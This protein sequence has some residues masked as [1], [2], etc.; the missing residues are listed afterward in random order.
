MKAGASGRVDL[1]VSH[2]RNLHRCA[3]SAPGLLHDRDPRLEQFPEPTKGT[4]PLTAMVVRVKGS[5]ALHISLRRVGPSTASATILPSQAATDASGG[6]SCAV[7][8]TARFS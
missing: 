2:D 1:G 8:S 5:V 3:G 7:C 4:H 6:S